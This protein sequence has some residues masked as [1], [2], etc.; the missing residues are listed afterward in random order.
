VITW[1]LRLVKAAAV[2]A[3]VFLAVG[4]TTASTG[5]QGGSVVR[6]SLAGQAWSSHGWTGVVTLAG[7]LVLAALGVTVLLARSTSLLTSG[8]PAVAS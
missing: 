6:G 2:L 3:F 7:C 4:F 5:E 8:S 1:G